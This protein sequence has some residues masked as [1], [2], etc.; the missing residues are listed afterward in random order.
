MGSTAFIC[1]FFEVMGGV[2]QC[3]GCCQARYNHNRKK[4]GMNLYSIKDF[5]AHT[6]EENGVDSDIWVMPNNSDYTLFCLTNRITAS[7]H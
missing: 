7:F 6:M 5:P 3:L 2:W 1:F 4:C